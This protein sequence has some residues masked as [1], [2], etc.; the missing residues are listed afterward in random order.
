MELALSAGPIFAGGNCERD[1]LLAW[2]QTYVQQLRCSR[3]KAT[4][5]VHTSAS[6]LYGLR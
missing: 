3:D 5:S 6:V 2:K 1:N 4:Q